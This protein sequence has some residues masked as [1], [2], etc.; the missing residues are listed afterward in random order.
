MHHNT[1]YTQQHFHHP[2]SDG[3]VNDKGAESYAWNLL[4]H[5]NDNEYAVL[6]QYEQWL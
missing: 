3:D 5:D 6:E 1:H 2:W 4:H